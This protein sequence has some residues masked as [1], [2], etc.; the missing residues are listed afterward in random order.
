[1]S[2]GYYWSTDVH[3]EGKSEL[4]ERRWLSRAK[5][6]LTPESRSIVLG[7]DLCHGGDMSDPLTFRIRRRGQRT[8]FK[9]RNPVLKQSIEDEGWVLEYPAFDTD[10]QGRVRFVLD[11]QVHALMPGR[12][13]AQVRRGCY[14]CGSFEIDLDK[15]CAVDVSDVTAVDGETLKIV[16]GEIPGVTDVFNTINSLDV[17]LCAVLE[18]SDTRLPL[19]AAEK[20]ELCAI[21]LCRE[22]ELVLT[23]GVKSEVVRFAGCTDGEVV[24]TRTDPAR[25]PV[26]TKL[27]FTWTENNVAAAA[28][29]CL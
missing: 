26:G 29:G 6:K 3:P 5:V 27:C 19:A 21:V 20:A 4:E 28:E 2:R 17:Q 9:H 23:D 10:I 8:V 7:L 18:P 13:E 24:V 11:D 16:N 14:V 25:F 22:V 12:Y 1:M 15:S